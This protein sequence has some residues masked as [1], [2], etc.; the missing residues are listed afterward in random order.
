[1]GRGLGAGTRVLRAP[2]FWPHSRGGPR[3]KPPTRGEKGGGRKGG[4]TGDD[5]RCGFWDTDSGDWIT[6]IWTGSWGH[7]CPMGLLHW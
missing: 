5:V 7:D 3:R 6:P 1:M 2:G 4:E